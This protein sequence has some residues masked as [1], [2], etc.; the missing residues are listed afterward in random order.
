METK[1]QG[2]QSNSSKATWRTVA[3]AGF[4]SGC[5]CFT[6]CHHSANLPS[7]GEAPAFLQVG[8]REL[9]ELGKTLD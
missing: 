2:N 5:L 7:G 8:L 1:A 3:E 6:A 4:R 9:C